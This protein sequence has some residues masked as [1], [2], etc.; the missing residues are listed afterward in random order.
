MGVLITV[1]IKSLVYFCVNQWIIKNVNHG[2]MFA[3]WFIGG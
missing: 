2:F 3:F 1:L